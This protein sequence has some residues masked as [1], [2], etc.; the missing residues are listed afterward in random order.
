MA[1]RI[2]KSSKDIENLH[3]SVL[4]SVV[5]VVVV[6]CRLSAGCSPQQRLWVINPLAWE[7]WRE[8]ERESAWTLVVHMGMQSGWVLTRLVHGLRGKG[9]GELGL[10]LASKC[11]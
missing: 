5:V 2:Y 3:C 10:T 4:N 11:G 7:A 1:S 8:R 6:L 9:S